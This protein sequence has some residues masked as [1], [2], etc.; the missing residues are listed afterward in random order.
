MKK[1]ALAVAICLIAVMVATPAFADIFRY[2]LVPLDSTSGASGIATLNYVKTDIDRG[3]DKVEVRIRCRR[4][5]PYTD[6][7]VGVVKVD[8]K[9]IDTIG[10]IEDIGWFTTTG[11]GVGHFHRRHYFIDGDGEEVN[12]KK[13][14]LVVQLKVDIKFVNILVD[15]RLPKDR[16]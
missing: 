13:I 16:T 3:V 7:R 6:Y 12:V 11:N 5:K 14:S 9:V 1:Y 10:E 2:A 8:S 15:E 4:L